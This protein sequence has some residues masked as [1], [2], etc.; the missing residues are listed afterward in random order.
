MLLA[1]CAFLGLVRLFAIFRQGSGGLLM[2][3][4][5][6]RSK[7]VRQAEDLAGLGNAT[8]SLFEVYLR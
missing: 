3:T 6:E 1:V 5:W 7:S 4:R 2:C 8:A